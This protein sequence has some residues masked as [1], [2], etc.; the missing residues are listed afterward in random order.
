[1]NFLCE[2]AAFGD[3]CIGIRHEC[4]ESATARTMVAGDATN[5]DLT[6]APWIPAVRQLVDDSNRAVSLL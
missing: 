3:L 6:V 1:M 5:G 2:G 4:I